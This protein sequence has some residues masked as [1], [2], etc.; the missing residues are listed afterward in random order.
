MTEI[1]R[2]IEQGLSLYGEGDLDGALLLWERVLV[3]DP[4]NAQANSYVDYVRMN[5]E[6]L[7]SEGNTEHSGPFGIS[8]DEPE[9]QIEIL[10]GEDVEP[11][12][13]APLF[14]DARDEGWV[15]GEETTRKPRGTVELEAEE[16]PLSPEAASFESA[17]TGESVSFEVETREYPSGAGRPASVLL[18]T[19]APGS[20]PTEFVPE[21]TPPFGS[22]DDLNTPAGFGSEPTDVRRRELG[23]VQ[24]TDPDARPVPEVP[25]V[26]RAPDA[27]GPP[28]LK[29]TLRTP[30]QPPPPAA[31]APADSHR[32]QTADGDPD[33]E[34]TVALGTSG[35]PTLDL[36]APSA[37]PGMPYDS[38]DLEISPPSDPQIEL[39]LVGRAETRPA[40]RD[41]PNDPLDL[42]ATL[43]SPRPTSVVTRPLPGKTRL[44]ADTHPPPGDVSRAPAPE[45]PPPS[46]LGLPVPPGLPGPSGPPTEE[47]PYTI[48]L[49]PSLAADPDPQ[50]PTGRTDF[51][52][53]P[54]TPRT[55]RPQPMSPDDA[56]KPTTPRTPRP[57]PGPGDDPLI[58]APTRELGLR[59]LGLRT[60]RRPAT[61]DEPTAEVDVHK[62]RATAR[63]H[64][65]PELPVMDP[66]D[67][68]SAEIL[69]EI[70]RN[71]PAGES[72][73]DRT[74]RRIT[75]LL[76]RA[77]EWGHS[78]DLDRSV[79]AVD[80][81][82]SEDPNSAL[83]QKLIHR[84]RDAIM[85]AFQGFLGDLQRT[86]A[87]ARP[88]H[89]LGS[90]PISPRAAFLLS[91]V[92]GT[93]SLDEILDV[94][95]MPRL[96]AYRYLCQLLLRGILR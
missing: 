51:S 52:D 5:Y 36:D 3:M 44:P 70:D 1:D 92:D 90:A 39:D 65:K 73:E 87:L 17:K 47:M 84:N 79:T 31:A 25:D 89:E 2:L 75:A 37:D 55:P 20:E 23:F 95:G 46:D 10:P 45:P 69:E 14:M 81:A 74:R 34:A 29:M 83:A 13:P 59:E 8:D 78:D 94:S 67:A 86:P 48:Q 82:L 18:R 40:L 68:R 42:L 6:L 24:P 12:S 93:L 61:E 30:S 27:P 9:Y 26:R 16:P 66:I 50:R 57:Q 64:V 96:E 62:I 63:A 22:A 35:S 43:P 49:D 76:E 88:L 80:L 4:E 91:R 53:K 19:G 85:N 28:E 7:T 21:Q 11:A 54:T 56:E 38:L 32:A 41:G 33:D 77:T 15:I 72:R 71:A 60:E 58:T